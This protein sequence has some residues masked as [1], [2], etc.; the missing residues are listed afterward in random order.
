MKQGAMISGSVCCVKPDR[1]T[2]TGTLSVTGNAT[3]TQLAFTNSGTV[4]ITSGTLT[5]GNPG[6]R[7][8]AGGVLVVTISGTKP[9][10]QFGQLQVQMAATLAG[11][12]HVSTAGGFV[13][14]HKQS[15]AVVVY[16][17]HSGQF[18]STSGSPSFGVAYG[19]TA[20][21]VV[22]P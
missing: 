11:S 12:L 5:A 16:R 1:V 6:Y 17:T 8:I 9:G 4:K 19:A 14:K 22:Y 7:Q 21:K 10:S 13:P 3:I 20:A 2:N 18:S 15:F